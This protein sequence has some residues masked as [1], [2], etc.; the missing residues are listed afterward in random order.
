V[1]S[2]R[3]KLTSEKLADRVMRMQLQLESYAEKN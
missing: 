3:E 1:D 2:M